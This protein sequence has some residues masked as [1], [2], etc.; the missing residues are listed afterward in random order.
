MTNNSSC[1][2]TVWVGKKLGGYAGLKHTAKKIAELIPICKIYCEPFA[3]LGRVAEQLKHSN[4]ILNDKGEFAYKYLR[5]H[6]Q[7]QTIRNLDFEHCMKAYDSKST[8]FLIDPVWRMTVYTKGDN[9]FCDRTPLEYYSKVLELVKNLDG[10]WAIC[11]SADEHEIKKI[12]SKTAKQC[13]YFSKI[14]QSEKKVIFGKYARTL[15][16]SNK[17]LGDSV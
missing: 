16:V 13:G 11:S 12:L 2:T 1:Q 10:D 8:F 4:M 9:T 3:G 5:K 17:P 6:F 7:N 14:I 15:L